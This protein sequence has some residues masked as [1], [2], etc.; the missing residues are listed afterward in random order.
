MVNVINRVVAHRYGHQVKMHAHNE[1]EMREWRFHFELARRTIL[2]T[3]TLFV[4]WHQTK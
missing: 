4:C 1:N 3:L 2:D